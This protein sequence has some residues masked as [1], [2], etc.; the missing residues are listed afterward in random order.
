MDTSAQRQAA[1]R[2]RQ[3]KLGK[4]AILVHISE[5]SAAKLDR[6]AQTHGSRAKSIEIALDQISDTSVINHD[7]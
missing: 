3:A 5:L 7:K 4:R 2:D 6:I 1:Y